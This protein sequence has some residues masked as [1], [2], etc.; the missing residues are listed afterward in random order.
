MALKTPSP[1]QGEGWGEGGRFICQLN[2]YT[3]DEKRFPNT[4]SLRV[5]EFVDH[6]IKIPFDFLPFQLAV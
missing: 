1:F 3:F 5:E 2:Y 4:L 6:T